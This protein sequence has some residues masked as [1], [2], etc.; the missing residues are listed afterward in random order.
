MN[1]KIINFIFNRAIE[2]SI[3][4]PVSNLDGPEFMT[5]VEFYSKGI[6]LFYGTWKNFE[7]GDIIEDLRKNY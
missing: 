1:K 5:N 3:Y 2:L 4:L 6:H 7:I